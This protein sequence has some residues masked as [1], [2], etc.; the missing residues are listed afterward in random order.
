MAGGGTANATALNQERRDIRFVL[1]V[2][3]NVAR[4]EPLSPA[5]TEHCRQHDAFKR[6]AKRL[7]V[8]HALRYSRTLNQG[9]KRV[10]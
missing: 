7:G 4:S 2:G 3:G 1:A 5:S 6:S 8:T 9:E 10:I